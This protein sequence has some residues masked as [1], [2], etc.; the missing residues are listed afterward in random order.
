M[1]ADMNSLIFDHVTVNDEN[2]DALVLSIL[3]VRII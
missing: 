1:H 3:C 2:S